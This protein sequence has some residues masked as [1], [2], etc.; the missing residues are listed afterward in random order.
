[1]LV[2]EVV[3]C[4]SPSALGPT[5]LDPAVWTWGCSGDEGGLSP[6]GLC[7]IALLAG[8][9]WA[10]RGGPGHDPTRIPMWLRSTM[11]CWTWVRVPERMTV[12]LV[13]D[14]SPPVP[15]TDLFIVLADIE[16]AEL[17]LCCPVP[18]KCW[19][20]PLLGGCPAFPLPPSLPCL[21]FASS[22]CPPAAL[23]TWGSCDSSTA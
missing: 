21:P 6:V 10:A 23:G 1:M 4:P 17:S 16:T 3:R 7:L 12:P 5:V 2:L 8:G 18:P 11:T 19:T 9:Y 15:P 20:V 22:C 13:S 14:S